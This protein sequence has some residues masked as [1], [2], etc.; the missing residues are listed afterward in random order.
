MDSNLNQ[1]INALVD[2]M[3]QWMLS[4]IPI[5]VVDHEIE[6]SGEV[7]I[8][9]NLTDVIGKGTHDT[10]V[11]KAKWYYLPNTFNKNDA[12]FGRKT[13]APHFASACAK[14]GFKIAMKGWE[15]SCNMIQFV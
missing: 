8:K 15:G 7:L 12:T 5:K 2:G 4:N 1:E 11:N 9:I 13:I 3:H 6:E 10:K 14:A